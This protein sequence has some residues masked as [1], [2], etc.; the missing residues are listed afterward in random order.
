MKTGRPVGRPENERNFEKT[1]S[2]STGKMRFGLWQFLGNI[3]KPRK[4][5]Q[6]NVKVFSNLNGNIEGNLT[7]SVFVSSILGYLHI[8]N[9]CHIALS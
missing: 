6:R 3:R 9:F 2:I 5:I 4:I 1:M 8:E 7:L